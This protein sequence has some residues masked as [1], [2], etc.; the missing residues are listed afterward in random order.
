MPSETPA[1][2]AGSIIPILSISRP[3]TMLPSAKKTIDI[4]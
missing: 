4:V 1:A 2:S 3:T